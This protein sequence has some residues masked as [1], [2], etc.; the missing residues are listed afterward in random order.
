M[1]KIYADNSATSFPKAPGVSDEMKYFLDNVGCNVNRGG[2]SS[3][4]DV[5]MKILDL[6]ESLLDF[7]NVDDS[8]NVVFTPNITYSLNFILNGYLKSGDHI[9]TTSLEHNSIMRPLY[10]LAQK[11]ITYSLVDGN[12]DGSLDIEKIIPL[13]NS[14]TKAIV[15]THASNI[16]G[17]ILPIEQVGEICRKYNLK[18]I[19]DT[20]QTA[21]VININGKNIDAIAFTGH[22]GLLAS[23]GIGGFVIKEDFAKEISPIITGGTGSKSDEIEQPEFLP[24]KFESGTMNIPAILGLKKSLEYVNNL[25]IEKIHEKEMLL[26]NR[27]ISQLK[28]IK[29]LEII[30]KKSMDSRLAVISLD[31]LTEDNGLV[32]STLDSKYGIMTRSGLHCAPLAHKTLNTYPKGTVRFSF[33]HFNTEEEVDYIVD[34]IKSII[35]EGVYYGF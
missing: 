9:I 15:M 27:F 20:A 34:S 32:A 10:I 21:G 7:F 2:Y 19:V 5:A 14:Q 28:D 29:E 12:A 3:S 8:Y 4:Y 31:F 18:F 6:R 35:N 24:D 22:K 30:G 11:G 25:G 33:G 26:T 23:Q 17:T 16:C 13:I 1:K